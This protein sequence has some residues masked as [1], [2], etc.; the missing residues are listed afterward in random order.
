[1][2]LVDLQG[3]MTPLPSNSFTTRE[4]IGKLC[5][6]A[7]RACADGDV[8]RL[9]RVVQQLLLFV[10]EPLHCELGRLA[11]ACVSDPAVAVLLWDGLKTSLYRETAT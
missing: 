1:M 10:P 7:D 11:D 2:Q 6:D 8:A 4:T 9:R 3:A 5:V